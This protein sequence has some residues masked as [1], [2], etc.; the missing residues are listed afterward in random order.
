MSDATHDAE[1]DRHTETGI[2]VGDDP[3]ELDVPTWED[4][5]VD[6]VSDRLMY[7]YDLEKDRVVDGHRFTL[8]GRMELHSEKHF[9]HPAFSFAHHES[10]EHLF[11]THEP[12]I[13][14]G[15]LERFVDLGHE[16]ADEWIEPNEEHFST[17]FTFVLLT[18]EIPGAVYD[19]VAS[20]NDRTMLKLGYNGHYEINLVVVAPDR[21]E[22]V[23]SEGAEVEAAFRL[24]EP[25][26]RKE[27][28]ILGLIARRL[29]L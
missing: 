10:F 23:S 9:L 6:R 20:F 14:E 17:D 15:T 22:L 2:E 21:E 26:E 4:E 7:N 28:G 8:Y 13:D 16:L 24:W 11:V 27:P 25:I 18:E 29:Q 3:D 12:R 19:H 5:Y 1:E